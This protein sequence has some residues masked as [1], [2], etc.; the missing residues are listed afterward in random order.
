MEYSQGVADLS[1]RAHIHPANG[2]AQSSGMLPVD[3]ISRIAQV[4]KTRTAPS[5]QAQARKVGVGSATGELPASID[6]GVG[7]LR[8]VCQ[9]LGPAP[10]APLGLSLM[11]RAPGAGEITP[12]G[13]LIRTS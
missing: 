10:G 9:R 12:V 7:Q 11:G 13:V 3:G 5:V 2:H 6:G 1:T 8:Q 4:G